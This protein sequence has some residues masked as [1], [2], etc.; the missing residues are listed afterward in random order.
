MKFPLYIAKRYLFSKKTH[1][2]INT[3]SIISVI[4]VCI[5]T[6]ALIIVLSVFNGFEGLVISLYNSFDPDVCVTVAKGKTFDITSFPLQQVKNI[7]GIKN[8]AQVLEENA[9]L[10][11]KDKQYIVSIKGVSSEYTK[12]SGLD[13]MIINGEFDLYGGNHPFAVVGY[14]VAHYLS[15]EMHD[16]ENPIQVWVP[17]SGEVSMTNPENAFNQEN[18]WP[19][20]I[21]SIQH[22]FDSKYIIASLDF[23]RSILESPNK[24]SAL[25]IKLNP[26]TDVSKVQE[27][28]K[29]IA[30]NN[31]DVKNRFEQHALLYKIMKSEKWAVYFILSFILLIATFNMVGSLTMLILDKRKDIA[32]LRSMGANLKTIRKIF[33]TE[34][35]LIA[36]TGAMSGILIGFIV[37][38]LQ[39]KFGFIKLNTSGAFVV[40]SYPV[41][42]QAM[43]FVY[44]FLTVMA[45]SLLAIIYPLQRLGKEELNLRP[46]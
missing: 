24:V 23:V 4:G 43:D 34:G 13:T 11:Y 39:I 10:K 37:C 17:K 12:V 7:S 20:G 3:I 19:S 36:L 16:I 1:N 30:G 22:E 18:I 38:L 27:E 31:Y 32:I 41:K 28:I 29:K 45:I 44:V 33:F 46:Q 26:N 42:I 21:F 5:G 35:M 8:I 6:A 14:G 15:L 25:E 2:A 9:L 40:D